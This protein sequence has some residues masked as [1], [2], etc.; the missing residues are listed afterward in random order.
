VIAPRPHLQSAP[1]PVHGGPSGREDERLPA[2]IDFSSSVNPWG[3]AEAVREA[4]LAAPLDRYPDPEGLLARRAVAAA[5]GRPLAEVTLGAGAAELLHFACF[6]YLAPGDTVLVPGPTFGEYARAAALCGAR[7]L[8]GMAPG[9]TL[10]IDTAVVA[11]TVAERRPRLVFLCAP[12]NPTGQA[13]RRGG[14]GRVAD[15]CHGAGSLLVL[16]QAYDAFADEPLG[17][18][19]LPGHPA[20]LHLRSITKDHALAGVRAAYAVAPPAII[21]TLDRVRPPWSVSAAAQAATVAALSPDGDAHLAA[22]LPQIRRERERLEDAIADLG[23]RPVPTATHFL[24]VE[25]GPRRG[26]A[27]AALLRARLLRDHGI[28]VRDCTSFGLP[29]HVRVATRTPAQNDELLRALEAVC[30]T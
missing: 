13:F 29:R 21:D 23:L 26:V 6:A 4:A 7:I 12:N 16:D 14:L 11:A 8:H 1:P 28:K 25:V 20:T 30:S 27:T 2:R 19:A 24:L 3:P 5:C 18:P 17:T 10:R 15:A 9:P 22:T